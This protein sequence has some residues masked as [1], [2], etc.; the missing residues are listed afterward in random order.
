MYSLSK[1][2]QREWNR[3]LEEF[4]LNFYE[5]FDFKLP[6]AESKEHVYEEDNKKQNEVGTH[7]GELSA[8]GKTSFSRIFHLP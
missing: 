6:S 1:D 5:V 7:A 8:M 2:A 4:S 3:E